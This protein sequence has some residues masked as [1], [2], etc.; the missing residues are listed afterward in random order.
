[1]SI[2]NKN[3]KKILKEM[4]KNQNDTTNKIYLHTKKRTYE[5]EI[6][7]VS[8]KFNIN[9]KEVVEESLLPF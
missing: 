1:M 8:V 5:F 7:L 4:A 2:L 3:F 6:K 9:N